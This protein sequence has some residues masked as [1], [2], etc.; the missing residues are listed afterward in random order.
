M[1]LWSLSKPTKSKFFYT[2]NYGPLNNKKRYLETC[3]LYAESTNSNRIKLFIN[4]C[5][6]LSYKYKSQRLIMVPISWKFLN[7][8]FCVQTLTVFPRLDND[9]ERDRRGEFNFYVWCFIGKFGNWSN[10]RFKRKKKSL[11]RTHTHNYWDTRNSFKFKTLLSIE[12]ALVF[13]NR[14]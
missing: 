13:L 5:K 12:Q 6:F 10:F 7:F 1:T 8:N 4:H 14:W 3:H 9:K 2:L 11:F